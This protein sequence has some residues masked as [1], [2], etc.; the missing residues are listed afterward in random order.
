MKK[1]RERA[2]PDPLRKPSAG[3][4]GLFVKEAEAER[5]G[6]A[7]YPLAGDLEKL[8]KP[9]KLWS[10]LAGRRGGKANLCCRRP[11]AS[12]Y[13]SKVACGPPTA[14][15]RGSSSGR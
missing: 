9:P 4:M 12:N 13:S 3:G 11:A 5:F 8:V 7:R 14:A 2:L 15:A 1:G 6:L 10:A